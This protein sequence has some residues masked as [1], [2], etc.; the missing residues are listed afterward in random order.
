MR[1]VL[2]YTGVIFV[3]V[4][5][6]ATSL[7]GVSSSFLVLLGQSFPI[8]DS[9]L[10]RGSRWVLN[11]DG[12]CEEILSRQLQTRCHIALKLR[13]AGPNSS[14]SGWRDCYMVVG[15]CSP[16]YLLAKC[17]APCMESTMPRAT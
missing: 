13:T 4:I 16:S 10:Y 14:Y 17:A 1:G 2:Q 6:F 3:I 8:E 5:C 7:L 12:S 11:E 9:R 15:Q